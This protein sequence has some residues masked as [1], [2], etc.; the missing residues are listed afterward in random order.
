[1]NSTKIY[2]GRVFI[3]IVVPMLIVLS[4][5]AGVPNEVMRECG[6]DYII[7]LLIYGTY[8][9]TVGNIKK[10]KT[11]A[12]EEVKQYKT[13]DG[14]T[15]DSKEDAEMREEIIQAKEQFELANVKYYAV[16]D[17]CPHNKVTVKSRSNT[18]NYDPSS[19]SYW[20]EIHCLICDRG[21]TEDDQSVAYDKY[22][23][24]GKGTK[25]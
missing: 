6:S 21:W 16:L 24:T 8:L 4:Q 19:D 23:R 1:M 10:E 17:K 14:K 25:I 20:S 2:W 7:F 22:L 5:Y 15:Y 12:I 13:S 18:G 11:M 3:V 9:N